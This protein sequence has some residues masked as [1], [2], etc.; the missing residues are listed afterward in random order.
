[1]NAFIKK[2]KM[3]GEVEKSGGVFRLKAGSP[4]P[5]DLARQAKD[6]KKVEELVAVVARLAERVKA[7]EET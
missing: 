7:L 4:I 3:P 1:M 5:E 6:C 2:P